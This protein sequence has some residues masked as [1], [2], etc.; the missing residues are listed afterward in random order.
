MIT[1]NIGFYNCVISE[2]GLFHLNSYG[3][4]EHISRIVTEY[5]KMLFRIA[6]TVLH[7]GADAED[8]VQDVFI[9]LID[10]Q[11]V[12]RDSEHEKAWLIRVT[13][14]TSRNIRKKNARS[15]SEREIGVQIARSDA[16]SLL[17]AVLELPE[18]YSTV[19]HLYY[20]EDLPIRDI[21]SILRLP[22]ATVGTRLARGRAVLKEKL[23]GDGYFD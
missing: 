15:E 10:R 18:K 6:F 12:F 9:R 8:A 22:A 16:E 4:D 21:A 1:K 13:V 17:S 14:N 23:K 7:N 20:Y 2:R 11:P 5:S 3:T 19:L